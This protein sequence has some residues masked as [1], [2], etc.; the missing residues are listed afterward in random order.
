M[1]SLFALLYF[2]RKKSQLVLTRLGAVRPVRTDASAASVRP[3]A[4][5]LNC[6]PTATADDSLKDS[7]K[8]KHTFAKTLDRAIGC[9]D[10]L[11][12]SQPI[13]F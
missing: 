11:G 13:V 12:G 6:R 10:W 9:S 5:E 7:P 2:L 4:P 1:V 8:R 3:N